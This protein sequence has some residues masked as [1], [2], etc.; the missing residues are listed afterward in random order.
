M[1]KI[2]AKAGLQQDPNTV[3]QGEL[4]KHPPP[5][6]VQHLSMPKDIWS[7]CNTVVGTG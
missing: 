1:S 6:N 7:Q 4:W 3:V 5:T 2:L